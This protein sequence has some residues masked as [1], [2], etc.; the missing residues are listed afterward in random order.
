MEP[1]AREVELGGGSYVDGSCVR[2][3]QHHTCIYMLREKMCGAGA[4]IQI[5]TVHC[6][7]IDSLDVILTE[8][9]KHDHGNRSQNIPHP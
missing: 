9:T 4:Q 1:L 5:S 7:D 6:R 8:F 2:N 3:S